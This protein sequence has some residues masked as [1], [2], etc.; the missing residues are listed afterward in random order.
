MRLGIHL[1][2]TGPGL[3]AGFPGILLMLAGKDPAFALVGVFCAAPFLDFLV[4]GVPATRFVFRLDRISGHLE[5]D[6]A[7]LPRYVPPPRPGLASRAASGRAHRALVVLL[8]QRV[9]SFG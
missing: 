1:A 7:A 8:I 4:S 9:W 5:Q 6:V 2:V 3:V